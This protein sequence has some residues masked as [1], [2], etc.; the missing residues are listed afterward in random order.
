MQDNVSPNM[1]QLLLLF[2]ILAERCYHGIFVSVIKTDHAGYKL[3][4]PFLQ[5]KQN[6]I[7]MF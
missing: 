2:H 5:P 4:K 6:E 3:K 7:L 1:L